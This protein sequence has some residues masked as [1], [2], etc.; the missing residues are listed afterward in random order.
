MDCPAKGIM[1]VLSFSQDSKE[2]TLVKDDI[3]THKAF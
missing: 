1:R 3:P 2:A